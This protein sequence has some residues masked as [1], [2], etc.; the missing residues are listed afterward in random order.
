MKFRGPPRLV[1]STIFVGSVATLASLVL[2]YLEAAGHLDHWADT[3]I[4][5]VDTALCVVMLA[6][7]FTL[8][9]L[10]ER[11]W[12]F[13]RARW[14]DLIAA[15]PLLLFFRPFRI[16]RLLR[17]L[18]LL[19]GI[20]LMRRALR[21]W[22]DALDT[23]LLRS[24]AIVAAVLIVGAALVIQD[25]ERDNPGLDEFR[26]A[27]WWAIVTASTVGYGDRYP[28]TAG[29]QIVAVL[30][31]IVGIGLFG[32]LAA[33]LTQAFFPKRTESHEREILRRLE[34]IEGQLAKLVKEEGQREA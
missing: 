14:I 8:L 26:E 20:A 23:A 28:L 10:A 5:W 4:V 9:G 33:A 25:F 31:M 27:L 15:I 22:E 12:A 1:R 2:L 29:G 32:T 17:L 24:V 7:W 18:R 19:R 30:L 13:V 16:I 34:V 3:T 11:K 6:E 21:P